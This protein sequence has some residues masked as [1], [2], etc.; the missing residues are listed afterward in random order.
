[1]SEDKFSHRGSNFPHFC[2]NGL[3][4]ADVY[5]PGKAPGG[6][7]GGGVMPAWVSLSILEWHGQRS[8][9]LLTGFGQD[10]RPER[11]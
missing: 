4:L 6:E 9:L 7:G 8:T 2:P 5:H 10:T 11:E 1:M 3:D